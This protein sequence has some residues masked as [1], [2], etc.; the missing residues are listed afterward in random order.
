LT[1]N[2]LPKE[3]VDLII[4]EAK[5]REDF[6]DYNWHQSA[7]AGYGI[8]L[9]AIRINTGGL[10]LN[11]L[12]K[13]EDGEVKK[14]HWAWY[15]DVAPHGDLCPRAFKKSR[16]HPQEPSKW[17]CREILLLKDIGLPEHWVLA[18]EETDPGEQIPGRTDSDD[19]IDGLCMK[20]RS[21]NNNRPE[22]PGVLVDHNE[23][24]DPA[25]RDKIN[26]SLGVKRPMWYRPRAGVTGHL[27]LVPNDFYHEERLRKLGIPRADYQPI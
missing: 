22:A 4:A 2:P 1:P 26:G 13:G 18:T 24:T 12:R 16:E 10:C 20:C 9:C 3:T 11:H 19:L 23:L 6:H 5:S 25:M 7:A 15:L 27:T 14:K 8:C 17:P 21:L